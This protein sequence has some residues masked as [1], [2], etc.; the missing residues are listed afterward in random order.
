MRHIGPQVPPNQKGQGTREHGTGKREGRRGTENGWLA[1]PM[2]RY[3]GGR[4]GGRS[5]GGPEPYALKAPR[6]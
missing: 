1:A 2:A 5:L 4:D 6:P 3:K